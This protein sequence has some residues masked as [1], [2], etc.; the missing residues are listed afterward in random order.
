MIKQLCEKQE[1]GER[2]RGVGGEGT[3]V[4]MSAGMLT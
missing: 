1:L 4:L 3:A 2:R